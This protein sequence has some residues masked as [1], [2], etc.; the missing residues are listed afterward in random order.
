VNFSFNNNPFIIARNL[1]V[2]IPRYQQNVV[3]PALAGR[4]AITEM[5]LK[6]VLAGH[7]VNLGFVRVKGNRAIPAATPP[8]PTA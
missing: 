4:I 3:A 8:T 7:A 2:K 6:R 1:N 5:K